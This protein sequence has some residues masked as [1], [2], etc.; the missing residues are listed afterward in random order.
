MANYYTSQLRN[1]EITRSIDWITVSIYAVLVIFGWLNIH[2]SIYDPDVHKGI[3]DFNT[4]SG[5]QFIWICT[6]II[7]LSVILIID[8]RF[9]D[10]TAWGI[11]GAV[12][13]LLCSVLL[14]GKE[15]KGSK[16]WFEIGGLAI[17]P[18]EFAKMGV[19]LALAKFMSAPNIKMDKLKNQLIGGGIILLPAIMVLLQNDTGSFLVFSSFLIV[20][21][22]EGMSPFIIIVGAACA[23]LLVLTLVFEQYHLMIAFGVLGVS[24]IYFI[25]RKTA[26]NILIVLGITAATIVYIGTVDYF[27]NNILQAHQQT[28]LKVLVNPDVDPLGAGWQVTQAKIA[29]GSGGFW[30]KG[31]LQG[32]QTKFDFVPDQSTDNIFCTV[33]EEHGWLGSFILITLFMALFLRLIYLAE[34]QKVKFARIFG[35]CV[36]SVMFFHFTINIGMTIGLFPVIGIPLPFFSYGGSSLWAFSIM[37][38]MFLNF[39]ASRRYIL[40]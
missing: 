40:G 12:F 11:Y 39:D 18:A 37:L 33:G 23:I 28:R 19:A 22:R 20:F 31:Y 14:F 9:Y 29:I 30:G 8:H 24:S 4:S 38:F 26:T 34:R 21:Y 2:A 17:Q 1:E 13:L 16:S 6:S 15:V 32:T 7:L 36:A 5:K 3:M 27:F 25:K 35:Y 10:T